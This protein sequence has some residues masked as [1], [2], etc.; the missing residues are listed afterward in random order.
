MALSIAF[1]CA[2]PTGWAQVGEITLEEALAFF[3]ENNYNII[4]NKYEVDKAYADYVSAK[5]RPNPNLSVNYNNLEMSQGRT[6][7]GDNTQL[8][9]R[10][11]Q[12]IETAG[13]KTLRTSAANEYLEAARIMHKDVIRNLLIGFYNFYY[14][15]NLDTLN[16]EFARDELARYDKLLQIADKRRNAGF[17]S[18]IDYTKLK[19]G[20]IEVEN[21]AKNLEAQLNN[22]IDSFSVLL[23]SDSTRRPSGT[24][25]QNSFPKYREEDLVTAAHENRY[26]LLSMQRQLKA[27][28]HYLSLAKAS[29]IPDFSIGG[30]YDSIGNPAKT[31]VGAGISLNIPIFNRAQGEILKRTAEKKQ[32]E[33]QITQLKRKIVSEV[34]QVLNNYNT[35]LKVFDSYSISKNELDALIGKSSQAFTLGGITVLELLDVQKTYKDFTTKYHQAFTQSM[36]NKELIKVYTGAMK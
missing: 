2:V 29:R 12:L 17:L 13:K 3:Y 14:M 30:E 15:I 16:L 32:I 7:R 24:K 8:T 26:D 1:C 25:I 11:D 28:D 36:L 23:G 5:L 31:G 20:R 22:S 27:A 34:Y 35:S 10:V 18:D 6:N 4:V 19:L 9:I 33:I 21:T